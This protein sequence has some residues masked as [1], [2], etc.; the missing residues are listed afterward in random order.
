LGRREFDG[1]LPGS[2]SS[3]CCPPAIGLKAGPGNMLV[4]FI[5]EANTGKKDD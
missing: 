2:A 3:A 4:K 5:E 1:E